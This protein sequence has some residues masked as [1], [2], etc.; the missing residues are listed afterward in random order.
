MK[1]IELMADIL[2]SD[3]EFVKMTLGDFSDADMLARPVP[4]ANHATWQLGHLIVSETS[5]V[6]GVTPGAMP[7]LPAGFAEKFK[8]DTAKINDAA[9][10]PRKAE[11]IDVFSKTRAASVKWAKGLTPA[12]LDQQAR[13]KPAVVRPNRRPPG[14]DASGPCGN[15]RRPVSGHSPIPE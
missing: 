15:A 13:R 12:D 4:A 8:K 1:Q 6:N 3:A 11:L 7:E 2:A 10:F 5:M 9:A 14:G